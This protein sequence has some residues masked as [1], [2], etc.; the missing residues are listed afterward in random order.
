MSQ[1]DAEHQRFRRLFNG[2]LTPRAVRRMDA[3]IRE[4]VE[5]FAAPLRGREGEVVD[6]LGDFTNPIP[7]TVISRIFGVQ[8]GAD[9]ARFRDLAQEMI[10]GFFPFAPPEALAR[11]ETALQEMAPWVRRMVA[12]RR[13]ALREDLISDLLRAQQDERLE[14]R[15]DRDAGLDPDRRG[16]RDHEPRRARDDPDPARAPRAARARARRPL[17][18]AEGRERDHALRVRRPG[19]HDALRRARLRAARQARSARAR[20]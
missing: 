5:R 20:C 19:R 15:R 7:N 8:P 12:E 6:L 16:Q 14:R 10:R 17:A 2:A 18:R 4:V 13:T 3:Q 11:A 1:G 9:E